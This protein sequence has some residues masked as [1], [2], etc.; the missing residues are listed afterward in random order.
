M[1]EQTELE[2]MGDVDD[3]EAL[4]H[5]DVDAPADKW[6]AKLAEWVDV[7]ARD[8]MRSGADP[9]Q[10]VI[11]AKRTVMLLANHQGGRP[12]YLP[13]GDA[14]HLALRDRQIYLLHNGTN[15]EELADRFGLTLR[16]VQRIYAEQ[17]AL[18]V[19]RRQRQLFDDAA[20]G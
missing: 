11:S 3:A 17:R 15:G 6:P 1:V 9:D 4:A 10:A 7:L 20:N 18:H 19:R 14:L 8:A 2:R 16:H 13:R 12:F 5:M